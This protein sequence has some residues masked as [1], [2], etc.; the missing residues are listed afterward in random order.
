MSK[1]NSNDI[2]PLGQHA[3][4]KELKKCLRLNAYIFDP[5]AKA[6]L[7][8]RRILELTVINVLKGKLQHE[9]SENEF[10]P[11]LDCWSYA[12]TGYLAGEEYKVA[13]GFN[14]A[15]LLIITVY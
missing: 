6:R 1:K 15:G 2:G 10:N 9:P 7:K 12:V 13:I 14:E 8:K 4:I 11:R 5:H 3:V